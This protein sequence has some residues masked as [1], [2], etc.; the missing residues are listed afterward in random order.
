[1]EEYFFIDK[2]KQQQG[3]IAAYQFAQ[4][5]VTRDTKVWKQGMSDWQTVGS[6]P[7]L[8]GFLPSTPSGY[9]QTSA[10]SLDISSLFIIIWLGVLV[11]TTIFRVVIQGVVDEWYSPPTAYI[12]VFMGILRDLCIILVVLAIKNKVL[13]IIGIAV[14]SPLVMYFLYDNIRWMFQ[15]GW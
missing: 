1:M 7:G 2:N 6:L 14:G 8:S 3:P 10:K 15:L 11:F 5:G 9:N 12:L 4:F 13:K